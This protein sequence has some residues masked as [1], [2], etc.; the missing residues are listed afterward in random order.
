LDA[1]VAYSPSPLYPVGTGSVSCDFTIQR[2]NV[3][4]DEVRLQ[5]WSNNQERLLAEQIIPVSYRFVT[6]LGYSM[7]DFLGKWSNINPE[8]GMTRLDI[9][10][11]DEQT[12]AFHGY[13]KCAPTDCIWDDYELAQKPS[14]VPFTPPTLTGVY[15]F[16]FVT[17]KITVERE[18]DALKVTVVDDYKDKRPT[19]TNVYLMVR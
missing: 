18:G 15:E 11:I 5:M 6:P 1:N 9:E 8:G 17:T 10:K 12:V 16:S 14:A 4:V 13:G 2:G 19:Q 3:T 7:G